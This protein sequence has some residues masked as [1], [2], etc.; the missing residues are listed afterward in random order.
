VSRPLPATPPRWLRRLPARVAAAPIVAYRYAIS[1]MIGPRCRFVPS[2]SEYGLQALE[3]FGC[4]RGLWLTGARVARC[5]PWHD[6][7]LDPLPDTF[8]PPAAG[9]SLARVLRAGRGRGAS[10]DATRP[11]AV[12]SCPCAAPRSP[13]DDGQPSP[14]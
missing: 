11:A 10:P 1:P 13:R 7:G 12:P 6:G 9:R 5:H 3:R 2:C 14:S 4:V 8:E